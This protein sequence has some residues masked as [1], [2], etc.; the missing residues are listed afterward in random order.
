MLSAKVRA[1]IEKGTEMRSSAD[2][3]E[4]C[5]TNNTDSSQLW[6]GDPSSRTSQSRCWDASS[7]WLAEEY[8]LSVS[9]RMERNLSPASPYKRTGPTHGPITAPQTPCSNTIRPR[10]GS[11][12][13]DINGGLTNIQSAWGDLFVSFSPLNTFTN[14]Q[15]GAQS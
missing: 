1:G 15:R 8:A 2:P 4:R 7:S 5:H 9:L 13:Q 12:L 3:M 10:I 11:D 14:T 6:M